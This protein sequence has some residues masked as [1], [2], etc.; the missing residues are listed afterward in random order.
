MDLKNHAL[1]TIERAEKFFD[2]ST[3]CLTEED[4]GRRATPATW[5]VASQV[6]HVAQTIDWFR[7]GL[8]GK[9]DMDF[10]Q[11]TRETD[12]V[13]SLAQ[14]R[15]NLKGAWKRFRERLEGS[16][17]EELGQVLPENPILGAVARYYVIEAVTDHTAHHRGS[18]AIFARLA[19]KVPDMPYGEG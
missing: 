15:E 11:A 13:T 14:A 17:A 4:S 10:E 3:R 2:R 19:G 7:D 6:A 9:W 12:A 16:S 1:M 5:T 18:L 8:D